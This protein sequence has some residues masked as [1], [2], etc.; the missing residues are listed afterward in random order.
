MLQ[1]GLQAA[2]SWA[3]LLCVYM[4]A[5][6]I[7]ELYAKYFFAIEFPIGIYRRSS[8]R[9]KPPPPPSPQC[10][11]WGGGDCPPC[12]P[13]PPPLPVMPFEYIGNRQV[14]IIESHCEQEVYGLVCMRAMKSCVYFWINQ[15]DLNHMI[16]ILSC[17]WKAG[18][19]FQAL[20]LSPSWSSHWNWIK[21]YG[22]LMRLVNTTVQLCKTVLKASTKQHFLI[23]LLLYPRY[24]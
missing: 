18:Q 6:A 9:G 11:H 19:I 23:T 1:S 5:M 13:A 4:V 2:V 8:W 10:I 20:F 3:S 12:P 15:P 21:K 22:W 14:T 16:V 17:P 24:D 7:S